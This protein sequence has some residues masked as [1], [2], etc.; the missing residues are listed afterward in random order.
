MKILNPR[1][2]GYVDYVA[3]AGL[4]LAPTLFGFAGVPATICYILAVV[5]LVMSL[6]T[7]YPTSIAKVIPFTIHGGVEL[8]TSL[9]LVAAPWIFAFSDVMA[10]RNFFLVSGAGLLLVYLVTDYKAATAEG[11]GRLSS[12]RH[13][14]TSH[15]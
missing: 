14:A 9:F 11:H 12:P 4:A 5:Q 15:V 8:L 10:A 13:S 7:A 2:H 6:T 1:V 3:V